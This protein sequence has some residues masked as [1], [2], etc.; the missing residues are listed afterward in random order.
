MQ[1]GDLAQKTI[2]KIP[3]KSDGFILPYG[4]VGIEIETE[5]WNGHNLELLENRK[6]W[7]YHVDGSLRNNGMEFTTKG[8]LVGEDI[9]IAVISFCKWAKTVNLSTGYPRAG[10][11]VHLDCT[12]MDV[13]KKELATMVGI[14]L[15][16]EHALFGIAG[17]WRR[18]C[19]FCDALMDSKRNIN[20]LNKVLHNKV[21]NP[22]SFK[23]ALQ[24]FDRYTG[25]NLQSLT[26]YGTVE[27][28]HLATTY[29]SAKI[30]DWINLIFQIKKAAQNWDTSQNFLQQFSNQGPID[31][32]KSI[33]G[34]MWPK[35][36]KYYD[37]GQAWAAIDSSMAIIGPRSNEGDRSIDWNVSA[38]N[39][40][41]HSK[42]TV[43]KKTPRK[44]I[45]GKE[46]FEP[47]I[48]RPPDILGN[49][50]FDVRDPVEELRRMVEQ[51][52]RDFPADF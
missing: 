14:Y 43:S 7:E 42:N 2:H 12:D 26:K 6:L 29:E 45:S 18:W 36:A 23:V 44:K 8:G 32:V 17:E 46:I 37:V 49:Q 34:S 47:L 31:F 48:A 51:R 10:I 13:E 21:N 27:F 38:I 16:I 24:G 4:K 5:G 50:H 30:L 15:L 3:V 19:G 9:S 11:H 39:P 22:Q 1:L 35:I 41:L 20:I 33:M 52:A 25:L 40:I 28:R